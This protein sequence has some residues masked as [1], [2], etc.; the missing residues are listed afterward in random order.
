M[1]L[2]LPPIQRTAKCMPAHIYIVNI[3]ITA[4]CLIGA[5]GVHGDCREL[6]SLRL[7]FGKK[8]AEV[9]MILTQTMIEA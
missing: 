2:F 4:G 1:H 3:M 9:L 7:F 5:P 8:Q 6:S